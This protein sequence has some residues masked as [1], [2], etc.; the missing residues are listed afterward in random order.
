MTAAIHAD[1]T[2]PKPAHPLVARLRTS[3]LQFVAFSTTKIP[4]DVQDLCHELVDLSRSK[5]VHG[6]DPGKHRT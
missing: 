1:C 2:A 5:H 6:A 3:G 4:D